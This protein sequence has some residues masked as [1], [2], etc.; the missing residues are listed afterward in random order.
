MIIV[1][2]KSSLGRIYAKIARMNFI[3]NFREKKTLKFGVDPF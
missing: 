2:K 3:R 1:K